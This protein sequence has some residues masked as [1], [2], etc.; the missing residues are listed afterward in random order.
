MNPSQL[1]FKQLISLI[2]AESRGAWKRMSFFILCIAI[3]VG[4]V[5]TVKSFSNM[6][7]ATI[8][9][10]AKGLLAADIAIKGSWQQGEEDLA[11]Q[12]KILPAGT[13]FL[14]LK[15]LHGMAQFENLDSPEKSG[16]MI[17][18]LKSIPLSGPQY[19][20]YGDFKN[21]PDLPLQELLKENGAVVESSFL[22]KT[23]LSIGDEFSLGKT[24]LKIT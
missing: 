7:Q 13:E 21:D 5:M 9:G 22:I 16:S 1:N 8:Q 2:F 23:G 11:Y 12:K 15:E 3:G 10:Q 20:F 18:E 19:P 6:V 24:K 17:T 4:A 14:F